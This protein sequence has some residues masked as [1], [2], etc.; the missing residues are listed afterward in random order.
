MF[1]TLTSET[2]RGVRP[3]GPVHNCV[4]PYTPMSTQ[5]EPISTPPTSVVR[6]TVGKGNE[7]TLKNPNR[8]ASD[9]TLREYCDK[10]YHQLLP[11]IAEKVHQ[12]KAQQDKLKDV[13][14]HLNFEGCSRRNSKI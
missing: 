2:N 10:H 7:Q 4:S 5:A 9:A 13:K 14:A 6:S 11:L 3:Y 8:P 12:G 1:L